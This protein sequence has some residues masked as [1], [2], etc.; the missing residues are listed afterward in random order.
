MNRLHSSTGSYPARTALLLLLSGAI[1]F[2]AVA[3]EAIFL[4]NGDRIT[5]RIR[6][7][8]QGQIVM[9]A[10]PAFEGF[11]YLDWTHVERIESQRQFQFQTTEGQR[12]LGN[13]EAAGEAGSD[14]LIATGAAKRRL[15]E[16]EVVVVRETSARL[17]GLLR[18][19][20]GLSST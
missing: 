17:P 5:G 16:D 2:P 6:R 14:L 20:L 10:S 18:I 15:D 3:Q 9:E 13:I 8:E 19:D 7:L 1:L 4:K 11:M 12:F